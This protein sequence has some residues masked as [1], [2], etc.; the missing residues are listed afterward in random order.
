M[1]A[2]HPIVKCF[3]RALQQVIFGLENSQVEV[4]VAS[5]EGFEMPTA[6]AGQGI[7]CPFVDNEGGIGHEAYRDRQ[8]GLQLLLQLAEEASP[9]LSP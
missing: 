2:P 5:A 7:R 1:R 3:D 8:D 6:L 9:N 4:L